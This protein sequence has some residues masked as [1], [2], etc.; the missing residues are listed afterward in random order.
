MTTAAA[1]PPPHQMGKKGAKSRVWKYFTF[2]L[3]DH[4]VFTDTRKPLIF[5]VV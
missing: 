5:T 4:D 1:H 2:Q 3:D